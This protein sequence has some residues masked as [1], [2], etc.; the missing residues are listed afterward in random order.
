[1]LPM[2]EE[3]PPQPIE[4][5]FVNALEAQ[6]RDP[7]RRLRELLAIPDRDRTDALWDEIVGLEIQLCPI[8]RAP[9][10]QA[11]YSRHREPWKREDPGRRPVQGQPNTSSNAKPGKRFFRR[12]NRGPGMPNKAGGSN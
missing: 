8:N 1:M 6:S 12:A 9:S 5:P 4:A 2:S 10:T 3:Q 11:N 7:H